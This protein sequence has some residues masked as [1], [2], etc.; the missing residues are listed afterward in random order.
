VSGEFTAETQRRRGRA[1]KRL[2]EKGRRRV[3][4][5]V[6]VAEGAENKP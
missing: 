5:G 2:R 1:K 3:F 6:E 4:L